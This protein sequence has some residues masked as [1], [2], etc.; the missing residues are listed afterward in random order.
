MVEPLPM[1]L[2]EI[3]DMLP[4]FYSF[5]VIDTFINVYDKL[6]IIQPVSHNQYLNSLH[7]IV[8]I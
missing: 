8:L 6:I 1:L 5:S 2:V 3:M 7:S 4:H